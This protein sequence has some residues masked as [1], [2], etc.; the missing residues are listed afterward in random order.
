MSMKSFRILV[1][2][3]VAT[4]GALTPSAVA[5]AAQPA[6]AAQAAQAPPPSASDA[7]VITEWNAIAERTIF[8]E[9]ELLIPASGLYFGFVSIAMY[10]AVVAIEGRYEPYAD[11]PSAHRHASSQ[12][13]AA[14]AAYT[15]LR[16]YF[17]ASA[18]QLRDDYLAAMADEP[19]GVAFVQGVRTG[20]TAA[21]TIIRS[22]FGD[23]RGADVTLDVEPAP[24]V[25]RPTPDLLLPMAVPWLG[26]VDPLVLD[27]PTQMPLRGPNPLESDAYARDFAETKAYG[28]KEGSA[29]SE[30]QTATALFYSVNVMVQYQSAMR[31]AVTRRGLDIV[32]SS[33]AFVLLNT[34]AADTLVSCWRAK[35]DYPTWRPITAI[36]LADTD[37]NDATEADPDWLPVV[38]TPPYSEYASGHACITGATTNT[39]SYLFGAD[40]IDVNIPSLGTAPSR[41]YDSADAL[42]AETMN[43]RIWLGLH[44]RDSM[45]DANQLGHAVSDWTIANYFQPIP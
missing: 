30:E 1:V 22:R 15:V 18:T 24:G 20:A 29:R 44:F 11:Q 7:A 36:P 45:I 33:R 39:F 21:A 12:V 34:A 2:A 4:A 43:A 28:E 6:Q 41:H 8:V 35:F 19:K 38:P 3:L 26:F 23:G 25:W 16:Y 14:T 42:D 17:P 27:S 9:N 5:T 31:D 40:S 10:D 37:G 13:A 32:E